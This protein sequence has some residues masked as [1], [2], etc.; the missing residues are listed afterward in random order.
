MELTNDIILRPRFR[1]QRDE[2]YAETIERFVASK[3]NPTG[4]KISNVDSHIFLRLPREDQNFWAPQLHIELFEL[5]ENSC[6]LRGFYGPNPTIWTLF[7]FLHVVV[8][9]LFMADMVWLYT[10]HNLNDTIGLQLG[11]ALGL[12]IIWFLLYAG[13]RIGKKKGKPGMHKL[14]NFMNE[15][16]DR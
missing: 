13:G 3:E 7:M 8:G 1:I 15:V 10:N 16:L 6:E 12:I 14:H 9:T 2:T 4:I 11:I 5:S